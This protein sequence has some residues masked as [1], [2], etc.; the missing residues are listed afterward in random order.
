MAENKGE[1]LYTCYNVV[2]ELVKTKVPPITES[3]S[4]CVCSKCVNDVLAV[5]LN[6]LPPKYVVT[7]QGQL[8]AKLHSYESQYAADIMSAVTKACVK[9][10]S[11]PKH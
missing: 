7:R 5:A 2:E 1:N 9:I 6:H 8:F 4:M 11:D 3:L 10:K